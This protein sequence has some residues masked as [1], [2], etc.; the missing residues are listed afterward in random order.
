MF[1][2]TFGYALR[3][4]TYVAVHGKGGVKVG[5]HEISEQLDIPHYFLGKIMQDMVRHGIIDSA[6]GPTGGFFANETTSSVLLIDILTITDG[7]LVFDACALGI[8]KCNAQSPCPLHD[9]FAAC[10]NG[11]LQTFREKTI[12]MLGQEVEKGA[13]YLNR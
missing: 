12:G 8:K 6:K 1:S 7:S 9:D 4:L 10:K 3:A 2:K 13:V 5:L 11:L